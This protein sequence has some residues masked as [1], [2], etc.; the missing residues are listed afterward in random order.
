LKILLFAAK[1]LDPAG[2]FSG[3]ID[4]VRIYNVA[5]T[6]NIGLFLRT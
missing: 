2:F 3:L 5:L 4:Y 6:K 1:D